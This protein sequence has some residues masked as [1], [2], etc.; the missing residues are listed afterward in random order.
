MLYFKNC[1]NIGTC[2]CISTDM[3]DQVHRAKA[4]ALK[5]ETWTPLTAYAGILEAHFIGSTV[6]G[7][8]WTP[9]AATSSC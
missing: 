5:S 9:Q 7:M 3:V 1:H 8:D 6:G 4:W 2:T